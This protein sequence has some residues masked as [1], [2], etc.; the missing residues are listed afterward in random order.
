MNV[1]TALDTS[2]HCLYSKVELKACNNA[3]I[4]Y[5]I[6]LNLSVNLQ[7]YDSGDYLIPF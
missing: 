2:I 7:Y 4:Q 5:F 3:L 1:V 6:A